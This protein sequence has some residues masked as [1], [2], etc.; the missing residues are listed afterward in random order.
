MAEES[1]SVLVVEELGGQKRKL[2]LNAYGLPAWGASWTTALQVRTTWY[3]GNSE[4]ATQ[5]VLGARELPSEW[6]GRW[7][8]TGL[9]RSRCTYSEGGGTGDPLFSPIFLRDAFDAIIYGGQLLRVT[10]SSRKSTN[11]STTNHSQKIVREGRISEFT[12]SYPYADDINWSMSFEWTGRGAKAQRVVATREGNVSG[13]L[14]SLKDQLGEAVDKIEGPTFNAV[15]RTFPEPTESLDMGDL[16]ALANAPGAIM[17]NLSRELQQ[18]QTQIGEFTDLVQTIRNI[19]SSIAKQA[20]DIC[21]N[22]TAKCNQFIDEMSRRS[23]ETNAL[24]G[25][26]KSLLLA[27]RTFGDPQTDAQEII[28]RARAI[29]KGLDPALAGNPGGDEN[30]NTNRTSISHDIQTIVV[31]RAGDTLPKIS[32]RV[33]KTAEHAVDIAKCNGLPW[34]QIE[35][36]PGTTLVCPVIKNGGNAV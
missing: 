25:S 8:R 34:Y 20:V 36:E 14:L 24:D 19:P 16:E 23:P 35:V 12:H 32:K 29:M 13:D 28:E 30:S 22:A 4:E 15:K 27:H 6:S 18:I 9:G 1:Q 17:E 3:P 11:N 10:W 26:L 5:H 7:S 33:Y 21:A 2:E 31:T